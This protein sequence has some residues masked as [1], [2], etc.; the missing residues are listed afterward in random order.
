MMTPYPN[1]ISDSLLISET[2][3]LLRSF[4]GKASAVSVVDFV[5]RIRKPDPNLAKMLV[6]DLIERDPRLSLN[7]DM[8]ELELDGF[9]NREIATTDFVVF[10]LETTGAKAPPCRITEI[11]AYR[12]RDGKVTEEF[13]TLVNPETPIPPFITGLTG[14]SD[15]MVKDAPLFADVVHDF[16]N[17]IG[18]SVLVAH[19]SGF[20]MR[21]LN[22]EIGRIFEDYRMANP[23]LCTVQLSRRL[24]PDITNHKLKTV[25][26]HYSID[27]VNHH[28]A[29][30]DAFATAHIFV[31]LLTQ[32]S[33]DG[34]IDLAAVRD[35]SNRKIKYA[36]P[37]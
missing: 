19:N 28:R 2:V 15:D 11:G 25:A 7:G 1:L 8:V 23:C 32:L 34:V 33:D 4:G 17:F 18:D 31:N 12:V 22:H 36:R 20:D 35:L 9:E 13:Q 37:T 26:E 5:M 30:A 10:D 16:L 29:S 27:L 3:S 24:L 21:F 14:I 6:G